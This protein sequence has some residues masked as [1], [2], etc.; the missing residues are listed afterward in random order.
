M[1]TLLIA[2]FFSLINFTTTEIAGIYQIESE[3]LFD[4][5]ELSK[6]GTF[7]YHSR[8]SS[9]W[10]WTDIK[11]K[12]EQNGS[13]LILHRI[14]SETVEVKEKYRFSIRYKTLTAIDFPYTNKNSTYKKVSTIY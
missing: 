6:Y 9:C 1:K 12:W 5:L 10:T 7:I 3:K 13:I 4:S 11:G 14:D 8:G 2:L